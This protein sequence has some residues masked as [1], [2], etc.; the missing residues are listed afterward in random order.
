MKLKTEFFL[1]KKWAMTTLFLFEDAR[2]KSRANSNRHGM[3]RSYSSDS[4]SNHRAPRSPSPPEPSPRPPSGVPRGNELRFLLES[5]AL[6]PANRL[7]NAQCGAM[8]WRCKKTVHHWRQCLQP[9]STSSG[10]AKTNIAESPQQAAN[11]VPMLAAQ[12]DDAYHSEALAIHLTEKDD[13]DDDSVIMGEE[14]AI[15]YIYVAFDTAQG[16]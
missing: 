11:L 8:C 12:S 15:D 9:L 7:G 1:A 4:L 2:F 16:F 10:S 3:P 14:D 6:Q 5:A 13:E